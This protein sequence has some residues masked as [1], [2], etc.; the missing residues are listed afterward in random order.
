M[1]CSPGNK[2]NDSQIIGELLG[3]EYKTK[4]GGFLK[5]K[6]LPNKK[7][8]KHRLLWISEETHEIKK[9]ISLLMVEDQI[10]AEAGTEIVK[11]V[12]TQNGGYVEIVEENGIVEKLILK[13]GT[14]IR[15]N[16]ENLELPRVFE[17]GEEIYSGVKYE[18]PV[19][20][21]KVEEGILTDL[22][23]NIF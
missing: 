2:I 5:F 15:N 8:D 3:T 17:A 1:L 13:V 12:K 6:D 4:T 19:L 7:K 22:L 18:F 14:V 23:M 16:D 21:E 9:D 11:D 10:Y 20:A